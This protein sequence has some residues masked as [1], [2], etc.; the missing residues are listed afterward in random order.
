MPNLYHLHYPK[1]S[2]EPQNQKWLF[3]PCHLTGQ[4]WGKWPSN[5]YLPR[6]PWSSTHGENQIWLKSW[7]K[8]FMITTFSGIRKAQHEERFTGGDLSRIAS[9][10]P[11]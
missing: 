1:G 4:V 9:G 6:G 5:P 7:G 8:G 11:L 10:A 3:Y 2:R